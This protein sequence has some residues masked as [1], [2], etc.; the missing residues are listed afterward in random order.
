M[1][2]DTVRANYIIRPNLLGRYPRVRF[3]ASR[4]PPLRW[5]TSV[6]LRNKFHREGG[7]AR[8]LGALLCVSTLGGMAEACT[9][10]L[11]F[12]MYLYMYIIPTYSC[13]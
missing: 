13:M 12:Y 2:V 6:I 4:R 8:W 9:A 7:S 10:V 3:W 1:I 11:V 5:S